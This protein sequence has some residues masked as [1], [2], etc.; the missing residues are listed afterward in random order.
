MHQSIP[1][2]ALNPLEMRGS[3]LRRFLCCVAKGLWNAFMCCG[4][5]HLGQADSAYVLLVISLT[6]SCPLLPY[7]YSYKASC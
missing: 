3:R 2:T 4:D 1:F 7:G 6:L 5:C